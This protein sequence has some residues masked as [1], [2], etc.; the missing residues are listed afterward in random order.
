VDA[1]A[2]RKD[3]RREVEDDQGRALDLTSRVRPTLYLTLLRT[4]I[5][6][7]NIYGLIDKTQ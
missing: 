4:Y 3:A 7:I 2:R 1:N 5:L 6:V